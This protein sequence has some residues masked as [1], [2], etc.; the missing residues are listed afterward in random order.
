MTDITLTVDR[1]LPG[2]ERYIKF[3]NTDAGTGDIFLVES[4]LGRPASHCSIE[5]EADLTFS[6][7]VY[8]TVV[9]HR[10]PEVHGSLWYGRNPALTGQLFSSG[11]EITLTSG[12]TFEASNEFVIR[13]IHIVNA[14]G[15]FTAI[16]S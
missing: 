6:F 7:N 10:V 9:P 8:K 12:E 2:N 16:L 11:V 3:S 1:S 15:T 4:T 14:A 5:A 13:D